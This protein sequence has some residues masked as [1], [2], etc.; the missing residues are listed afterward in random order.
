MQGIYGSH[1]SRPWSGPGGQ[2]HLTISSSSA[3]CAVVL[4]PFGLLPRDINERW[5]VVERVAQRTFEEVGIDFSASCG[6]GPSEDAMECPLHEHGANGTET[7]TC[8]RRELI[9]EAG[10]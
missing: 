6:G 7:D 4:G 10:V 2:Q 3:C 5:S 9:R 1:S 8:A